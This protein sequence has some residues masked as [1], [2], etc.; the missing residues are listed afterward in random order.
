MEEE[1]EALAKS[2]TWEIVPEMQMGV[3]GERRRERI[4]NTAKFHLLW[5]RWETIRLILNVYDS[6]KIINHPV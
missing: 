5:A 6:T 1:I 2:Y 3:Q 4:S